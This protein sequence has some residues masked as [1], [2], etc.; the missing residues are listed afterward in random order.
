MAEEQELLL[1]ATWA[2]EPIGVSDIL[3]CMGLQR[4]IGPLYRLKRSGRSFGTAAPRI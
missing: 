1:A 3:N 4:L 2:L